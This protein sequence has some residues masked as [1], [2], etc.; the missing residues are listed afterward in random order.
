VPA[1]IRRLNADI[2]KLEQQ[3]DIRDRLT[4]IGFDPVR[5]TPDQF[6]QLL[7]ADVAKWGKVV[8]DFGA[9]PD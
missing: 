3:K 1:V 2:E 5:N 8:R 9:K 6:L 7:K 4:A